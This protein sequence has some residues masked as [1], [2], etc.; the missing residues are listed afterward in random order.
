M[1]MSNP[2]DRLAFWLVP[3]AGEE[4]FF[5][6][7]IAQFAQRFDA[8][9]FEPHLTL[10]GNVSDRLGAERAFRDVPIAGKYA[11]EVA[12]IASS[13]K[14][15][16]TLFVRFQPSAKLRELRAALVAALGLKIE[17]TF[18]PHLSLLY[19]EMPESAKAALVADVKV[20]FREVNFDSMRLIAHPPRI[21]TRADV[22]VWRMLDQRKLGETPR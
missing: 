10:L 20:P 8:P 4:E 16:Q 3:A 19:Q 18:D 7:L 21:T 6:S 9:L 5:S 13:A 11:L 22:E 2:P 1:Q 14:F 17:A 12:G 15:T